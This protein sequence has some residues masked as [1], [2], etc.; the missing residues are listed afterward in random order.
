MAREGLGG[1][2]AEAAAP[3]AAAPRLAWEPRK[4]IAKTYK[5][6][7]KPTE[8]Y[9]NIENHIKTCKNSQKPTRTYKNI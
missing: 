7:E 6:L 1:D 2:D 3:E 5:N 8:T 4:P 9:K